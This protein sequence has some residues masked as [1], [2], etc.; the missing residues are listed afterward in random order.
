MECFSTATENYNEVVPY[1]ILP[2]SAQAQAQLMAEFALILKY[3]AA[4]RPG[5][6]P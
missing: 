3:P 5:L 2:S 4:G 1:E 6:V